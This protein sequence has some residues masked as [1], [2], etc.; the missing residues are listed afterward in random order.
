MTKKG[1]NSILGKWRIVETDLWDKDYLDM[2][3]PARITFQANG[4]GEFAFGA[5]TATLQC[6][7]ASE[8]VSFTWTGFDELDEVGGDGSADLTEDGTLEG[9][10]C[11]HNGDEAEFKACRE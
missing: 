10:I 7:H 11:F 3:G 5:V 9:E 2:L 1:R 4:T 8:G 6:H